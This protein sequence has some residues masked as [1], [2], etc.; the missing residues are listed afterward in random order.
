MVQPQPAVRILRCHACGA[1]YEYPVRDNRA[2]R[3]HCEGCA[4]LPGSVRATFERLTKR[5]RALEKELEKS[6]QNDGME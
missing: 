6:S 3:F 5:I 2:T 1:Q 4:D